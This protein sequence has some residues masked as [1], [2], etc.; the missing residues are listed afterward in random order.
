MHPEEAK[1]LQGSF[2]TYGG[3][4]MICPHCGVSIHPH[5][6]RTDLGIV[7]DAPLIAAWNLIVWA[8]I[9]PD[10][11]EP[12]LDM[13]AIK[14]PHRMPAAKVDFGRIFPTG[15]FLRPA[16]GEVPPEITVDYDEARRVLPLSPKSSA[17]LSRRCLQAILRE[18]GYPQHNLVDQIDAVLKEADPRKAIPSGLH[19]TIDAIRQFGNFGAHQMTDATTLQ[20]IEVQPGEAE[21]C[22]DIVEQAF[23]HYYVKPAQAAAKKAALNQK[24]AA[25]KKKPAK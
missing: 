18:Q 23:D 10:C 6:T 11:G 21:W 15:T 25:A 9:C 7:Q 2:E 17:A 8:A 19:Q 16:P 4:R 12:I 1:D 20:V 13:D 5:E 3:A 14:T 24:L 22:I